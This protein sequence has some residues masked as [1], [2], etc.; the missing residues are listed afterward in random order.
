[1]LENVSIAVL[2]EARFL[3]SKRFH[4]AKNRKLILVYAL[5]ISGKQRKARCGAQ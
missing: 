5:T 1:L 3:R 2:S 4:G